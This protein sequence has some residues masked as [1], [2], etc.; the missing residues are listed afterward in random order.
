MRLICV[1]FAL[2]FPLLSHSDLQEKRVLVSIAPYKYVV[3]RLAKDKVKVIVMVPPG[4]SGHT[5]E[6]TQKQMIEAASGTIWFYLGE[7]FEKKAINALSSQVKSMQFVNLQKGVSLLQGTCKHFHESFEGKSSECSS[8]D[9]HFWLSPSIMKIQAK[10]IAD[11]LSELMPESGSLFQERLHSFLEE[12]D[13]LE[14]ELKEGLSKVSSRTLLVSH[15]AYGYFC[16]DFGFTQLP[17]E[18][19]G[20]DPTAKQLTRLLKDA[21]EAN[22][23]FILAQPQ[24]SQKASSLIAKELHLKLFVLDPYSEDFPAF[25]I[26]LKNLILNPS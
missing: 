6:P 19:E 15:P 20:K 22:V 16:K 17:I 13:S 4:A 24:Y 11:S 10:T 1:L 21:K 23:S 2:F 8:Y 25:L 7:P 14:K 9:L 26:Q 18:F 5:Y 12:L 3:E